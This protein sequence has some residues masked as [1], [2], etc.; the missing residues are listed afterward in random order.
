VADAPPFALIQGPLERQ[1]RGLN[2]ALRA[3]AADRA[4]A[5]AADAVALMNEATDLALTAE[6]LLQALL[7]GAES[8]SSGQQVIDA[9]LEH[10]VQ[11]KLIARGV[12]VVEDGVRRFTKA[13]DDLRSEVRGLLGTSGAS[14]LDR[15]PRWRGL[16]D[17]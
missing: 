3:S 17:A 2:V 1:L 14:E 4:Y 12:L 13:E 15:D 5:H 10:A 7:D 11:R 6:D 8:G 9:L 16:L